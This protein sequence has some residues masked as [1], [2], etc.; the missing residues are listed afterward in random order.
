MFI[1]SFNLESVSDLT[2]F[3]SL[4]LPGRRKFTP[5]EG[6]STN[7][8]AVPLEASAAWLHGHAMIVPCPVVCLCVKPFMFIEN[9]TLESSW[10][11]IHDVIKSAFH[12]QTAVM[13]FIW[14][15][16]PSDVDNL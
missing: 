5:N 1:P 8:W 11:S 13:G 12:R 9:V 6:E 10:Y 7:R 3:G 15:Y 16:I 14:E 2:M 4:R